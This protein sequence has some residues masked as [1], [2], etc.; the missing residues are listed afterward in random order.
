M[1][2]CLLNTLGALARGSSYLAKRVITPLDAEN[3]CNHPFHNAGAHCKGV[4]YFV[5]F[6]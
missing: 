3:V 4:H 6:K 5:G 2:R 1:K